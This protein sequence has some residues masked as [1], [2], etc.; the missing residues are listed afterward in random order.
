MYQHLVVST[1]D[2]ATSV[3]LHRPER[4]NGL[5]ISLGRELNH[6]LSNFKM[7]TDC[8]L[9]RTDSSLTSRALFIA[10][11][12]T[13]GVWVAGGDLKELANLNALELSEYIDLWT[14]NCELLRSISVPTIAIIDGECI[15][16]AVEFALSADL[17]L[18]THHTSFSFKQIPV[19]LPLGYGTTEL[20]CRHFGEGRARTIILLGKKI[21]AS[22]MLSMGLVEKITETENL[23]IEQKALFSKIFS[24]SQYALARQKAML[25]ESNVNEQKTHFMA[26]W[27]NPYHHHY[28]EK[29]KK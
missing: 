17:R 18:V 25:L 19:G 24:L 15:G 2:T 23:E 12:P 4:R 10:A 7:S 22:E 1:V 20:L 13:N 27:R 6:F 28:L 16:G 9:T 11:T 5:G 21:Q 3:T 26:A 14:Q 8:I 29:F